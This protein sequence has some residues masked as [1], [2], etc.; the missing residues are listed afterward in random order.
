MR[1]EA[2]ARLELVDAVL[3]RD[4]YLLRLTPH[5]LASHAPCGAGTAETADLCR[6]LVV[7]TVSSLP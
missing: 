7:T 4:A 3:R 5:V 1:D 2:A 6:R